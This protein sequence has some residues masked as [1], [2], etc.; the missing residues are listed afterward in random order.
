MLPYSLKSIKNTES[1]NRKTIRTKNRRTM[2]YSKFLVCNSKN[3]KFLKEQEARGL[4]SKLKRVKIP[5]PSDFLKLNT[6]FWK[7]E[8]NAMVNRLLLGGDKLY[9][10]CI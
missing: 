10:K 2:L 5:V 4:L 1:K 7:Y 9:Q 8:I 6:L 3:L